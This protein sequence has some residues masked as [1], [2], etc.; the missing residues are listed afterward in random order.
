MHR[1]HIYVCLRV[2]VT[3]PTYLPRQARVMDGWRHGWDDCLGDFF[4]PGG[5]GV[6]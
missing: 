6:L 4:F 3:V 5:I 1:L 2:E